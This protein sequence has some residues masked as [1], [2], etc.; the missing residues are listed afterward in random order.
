MPPDDDHIATYL[1]LHDAQEAGK[2]LDE[3]F[4]QVDEEVLASRVT[5][6]REGWLLAVERV[7]KGRKLRRNQLKR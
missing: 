3:T 7:R 6:Y 4:E 5:A 2:D 1:L